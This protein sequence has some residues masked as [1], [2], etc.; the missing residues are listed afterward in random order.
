M[1]LMQNVMQWKKC[2]VKAHNKKGRH[3]STAHFGHFEN[4]KSCIS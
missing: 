3:G 2:Y 1:H 4:S